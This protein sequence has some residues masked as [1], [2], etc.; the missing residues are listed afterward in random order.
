[1]K[2]CHVSHSYYPAIGGMETV[3]QSLAEAQFKLGHDVSVITANVIKNQQKEE[4]LHGVKIRRLASWK[5]FYGDLRIPRESPKLESV[6]VLHCHSQNSYFNLY[7]ARKLRRKT[8]KLVYS[9]AAING[10]RNHPSFIIRKIGSWYGKRNT[11]GAVSISDI[12]LVKS[13]RDS[14][15]LELEYGKSALFLPDGLDE[16][17]FAPSEVS[18]NEFRKKYN[19]NE[20]YLFAFMGRLHQLKG[21]HILIEALSHVQEDVGLLIG[22]PDDGYLKVLERCA[23]KIGISDRVHFLGYIDEETK[24]AAI[25]CSLAIVV[26]SLSDNVEIY[27]LT[28]SE[29]WARGVPVIASKVGE[30][31]FRVTDHVDGFLIE[32]NDPIALAKSMQLLCS[33]ESF[34]RNLGLSGTKKVQTWKQVALKSI[35]AYSS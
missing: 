23:E 21:P 11:Q 33:D 32:P 2:I 3:V 4:L 5:M 19:V 31:P 27:S 12:R 7:V 16:S 24:K 34:S 10:F 20:K 17:F 6:D 22:G 30:M 13:R 1:M 25:D 29:A 15:Q 35:E 18:T 8:A 26:P 28:M 14:I 9:F